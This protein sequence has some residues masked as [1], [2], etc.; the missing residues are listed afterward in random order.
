MSPATGGPGGGEGDYPVFY[1]KEN[2]IAQI[3]GYA[4]TL[5][6]RARVGS[7]GD[8][9]GDGSKN[10]LDVSAFLADFGNGDVAAD[11]NGDCSFN[12]LDVSGFLS[13]FSSN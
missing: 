1:S 13:E 12:F 7:V 4:A 5:D 11:V 2:P 10:F 8:Y 6:I 3:F 9:N